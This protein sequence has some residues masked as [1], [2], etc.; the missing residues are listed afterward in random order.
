MMRNWGS[1]FLVVPLGLGAQVPVR[2]LLR[3]ATYQREFSSV[4][5]VREL[6]DGSILVGDRLERE[7]VLLSTPGSGGRV[8][9]RKGF[10]PNEIQTVS[11]M[12]AG[13]ADSTLLY[14]SVQ[15]RVLV[16]VGSR[17]VRSVARDDLGWKSVFT[18][19]FAVDKAGVIYG[20]RAKEST[21]RKGP[22]NAGK[23]S[24]YS[25]DSVE[26]MAWSPSKVAPASILTARGGFTPSNMVVK[27]IAGVTSYYQLSSLLEGPDA[28]AVCGDGRVLQAS[29]ANGTIYWWSGARARDVKVPPLQ[30]V[31]VSMAEKRRAIVESQGDNNAQFFSPEEYP[32]WPRHTPVF[33]RDGAWCLES[34]DALVEGT[35]DANG[36]RS[37]LFVSKDGIARLIKGGPPNGRIVGLGSRSVYFVLRTGD[38]LLQLVRFGLAE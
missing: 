31:P 17:V 13:R 14:D 20:V 6:S 5:A 4:V 32:T 38:G 8:L 9:L 19:P 11:A 29:P 23:L 37:R 2:S 25:A 22:I 10:G 34:G 3:D 7:L 12:I 16:L 15:R 33:E 21:L 30:R 26:L 24:P 35:L 18:F 1:L 36:V 28:L 27:T